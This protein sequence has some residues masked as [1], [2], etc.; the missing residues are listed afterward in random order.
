MAKEEFSLREMIEATPHG[1]QWLDGVSQTPGQSDDDHVLEK[2]SSLTDDGLPVAPIYPLSGTNTPSLPVAARADAKWKMLTR[3]D[4]PAPAEANA[5]LLRDLEQGADG[6]VLVLRGSGSSHGFGIELA[7]YTSYDTLFDNI[8]VDA[9]SL[10]FDGMTTAQLTLWSDFCDRRNYDQSR[11]DISLDAHDVSG[12]KDSSARLIADATKWHDKGATA[13][14]ELGF[15]L[16]EIVSVMC[17]LSGSG[18]DGHAIPN[19]IGVAL[20]CDADQFETMA[21]FR[22]MRLLWNQLLQAMGSV[23]SPLNIHATTSWRMMGRRDPWTNVLRMTMASFA[24]GLGGAD[25]VTVLPHTQALGLPD[26]FARRVARNISLILQEESH[27]G[28]MVDPAAGAGVYDTLTLSLAEAGWTIF[29]SLEA[30]GGFAAA[31]E[32]GAID[33]M[34]ADSRTARMSDVV[35]RK[36]VSLGN[37]HFAQLDAPAVDTLITRPLETEQDLEPFGN[38]RDGIPFEQLAD[39]A[40]KLSAHTKP[41]ISLLC[42]GS[43][44]AWKARSDFA[45]VLFAAG[46]LATEILTLDSDPALGSLDTLKTPIICLCGS[47]A[48]YDSSARELIARLQDAGAAHIVLAGRSDLAGLD[49]TLFTGCDAYAV[50][51]RVLLVLE[52]L[53]R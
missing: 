5:Q 45:S 34:V 6:A 37:S 43:R 24:A 36:I 39:R 50:L 13:A 40:Q 3:I 9:T 17:D 33:Q 35:T 52:G 44:K 2:L 30:Q 28:K 26:A 49:D 32:N 53:K 4:H 38:L 18:V 10:R 12:L 42:I 21:K 25:S 29:Q 31:T 23:E 16:A 14:Q 15:A 20:S 41:T 27:L 48:D 46:G 47:D 7:D 8:F 51:D 1:R 19:R 11:L 22:A